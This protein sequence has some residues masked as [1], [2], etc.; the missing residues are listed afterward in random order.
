MKHNMFNAKILFSVWAICVFSSCSSTNEKSTKAQGTSVTPTTNPSE[1]AAD[2]SLLQDTLSQANTSN[3]SVNEEMYKETSQLSGKVQTGSIYW[4][5]NEAIKSQ[6]DDLIMKEASQI[7][8]KTPGDLRALNAMAMSSYR[9]GRYSLSRYLL[10]KAKQLHPNS[11]EVYSN[12]GVVDLA[13]GDKR[14]AI[15]NFKK[16]IQL[17][18][19]DSVAAAN[20]GS[21]YVRERDYSKA[22][23]ALEISYRKG[24][25][26]PKVLNNY[27]IALAANGKYDKANEIYD[28]A[29]R[30]QPS[31][32]EILFNSAVLLIE[33]MKKYNEGLDRIQKLKFTGGPADSKNKI[34]ALE[35]KAKAG[36]K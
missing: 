8:L 30:L 23:V 5:L 4:T 18:S 20:I 12:L 34:I 27:A 28:E 31:S 1:A 19:D 13:V 14:S 26:D 3:P 24:L 35:N 36:L 22:W 29:L 25:R 9:K 21:L 11:A 16:A 15:L 32:K 17:N 7:L 33:Q 2:E 10:N 6:S